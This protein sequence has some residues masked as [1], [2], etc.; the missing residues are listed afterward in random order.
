M[1]SVTIS[2]IAHIHTDFPEKFGIPRQVNLVRSLRATIVFEE[3]Y[4]DANAVRG[5][6]GF[7]HLWIIWGFSDNKKTDWTPTI[8]PPRLGGN[9][10]V[11][12]F[13]SRSP[14]RPNP[15][16]LSAVKIISIRKTDD[17]GT[18][19]DVEG[20]DMM[21]GTPIYDIK[22]YLPY[23]D[24]HPEASDGYAVSRR[25]MLQVDF[26]APLLER[27]PTDKQAALISI[28]EQDPRG[29]YEKKPGFV[30]GLNF[31]NYDIRFTVAG[32]TLTVLDVMILSGQNDPA[33]VR[34][35]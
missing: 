4:R 7:S 8:R 20:A 31:S 12:V 28:L 27:I 1:S 24:C 13:A 17:Q 18:V 9:E 35:K 34:I 15:L 16:G 25:E 3:E 14:Y 2:P 22:P 21:D 33:F 11:G 5:L 29:A 26:P 6:E 30:Y 19:I 23:T 10:R 32:A